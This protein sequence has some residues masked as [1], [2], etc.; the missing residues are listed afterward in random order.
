MKSQTSSSSG[1]FEWILSN[2]TIT[3]ISAIGSEN[4]TGVPESSVQAVIEAQ[5]YSFTM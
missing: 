2:A 4:N 5:K 3:S 1:A